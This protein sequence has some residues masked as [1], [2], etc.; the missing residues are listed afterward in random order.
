MLKQL[1]G[2]FVVFLMNQQQTYRAYGIVS[3]DALVTSQGTHTPIITTLTRT[4]TNT[5]IISFSNPKLF[6]PS[7]PSSPR[8]H[9]SI[10]GTLSLQKSEVSTTSTCHAH[11]CGLL[12]P[13]LH[14]LNLTPDETKDCYHSSPKFWKAMVWLGLSLSTSLNS[15]L[16]SS[17]LPICMWHVASWQRPP[18]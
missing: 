16:A 11:L 2:T 18:M 3:M 1:Y 9:S 13:S 4:A 10:K 17:L 5:L 8:V 15:S 12:S 7:T 6:L 14:Q